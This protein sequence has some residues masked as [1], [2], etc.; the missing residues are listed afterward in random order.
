MATKSR[1]KSGRPTPG[2]GRVTPKGGHRAHRSS[3]AK[4]GKESEWS[5]ESSRYTAPTPSGAKSSPAWWPVLLFGL[6]GLGI[7]II[8]LDY[9]GVLPGTPNNWLLIPALVCIAG[10]LF[11]AMGYH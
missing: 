3:R 5:G 1:N 2:G 4:A 9:A 6:L 11:A 8:V 10:G 7:L